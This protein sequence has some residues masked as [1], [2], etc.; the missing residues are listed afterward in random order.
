MGLSR[1]IW[2]GK[3]NMVARVA[4]QDCRVICKMG[5]LFNLIVRNGERSPFLRA[6]QKN[7]LQDGRF[8]NS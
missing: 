7:F 2:K 4:G 6:G 5:R 1:L 3:D 8:G